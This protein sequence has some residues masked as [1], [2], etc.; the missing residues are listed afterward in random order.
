MIPVLV[1]LHL[2]K[3]GELEA[4]SE[5]ETFHLQDNYPTDCMYVQMLEKIIFIKISSN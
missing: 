1:R 2:A 4:G 3:I 5:N